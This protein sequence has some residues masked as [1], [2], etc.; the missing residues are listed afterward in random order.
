MFKKIVSLLM[1]AAMIVALAAAL[2]VSTAADEPEATP[3][4]W[5]GKANI[6]WYVDGK[7]EGV[8]E[9]HLKTAEDFAG[10]AWIVGAGNPNACYSGVYYDED[11]YVLG[12][13][14]T[15]IS[16][17]KPYADSSR[18]HKQ[19][20]DDG[21]QLIEG[22][23]FLYETVY[24]DTDVILNE[25]NAAD[26]AETAPANVWLPIGGCLNPSAKE[27]GFNGV[28]EGE[29]HT[30]SGAYF[31]T[32]DKELF[33][34]G[35]FGYAGTS[36]ASTFKNFKLKN[37]FFRSGQA[38]A[39]I[40]GRSN[41]PITIK[42]CQ[43][44][45][46]IVIN[47]SGQGAGLVAGVFNGNA[48]FENC[49]LKNVSVEATRYVGGFVGCVN[50][51][52]VTVK[53]CSITGTVTAK[54]I[55]VEKGDGN[56]AY[57]FGC[58]AGIIIGR[59]AGGS[60][61]VENFWSDV[62]V[63]QYGK[64][65]DQAAA[66]HNKARAGVIFAGSGGVAGGDDFAYPPYS[67]ESVYCVNKFNAVEVVGIDEIEGAKILD[68]FEFELI[69]PDDL[70]GGNAEYTLAGF[71]FDGVWEAVDSGYPEIRFAEFVQADIDARQG[72]D[73]GE[74]GDEPDYNPPS[75]VKPSGTTDGEKST[76]VTPENNTTGDNAGAEKKGCGSVIAGLPVIGMIALA[77]AAMI[78]RK[79]ED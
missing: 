78:R 42:N 72:E 65:E 36:G 11:Y 68:P 5:S 6:K 16:E 79:K 12:F 44:E 40:C 53:N 8:E 46:C 17:Q 2:P 28:F 13:Q 25:G 47:H 76:T 23:D 71:D 22:H 1:V 9:W 39:T 55:E 61:D 14:R 45:D 60:Y 75:P 30:I 31:S 50:G 51:V 73:P 37:S 66:A 43:V 24:L 56:I 49:Q 62:T 19:K 67:I 20:K 7:A 57:T 33:A 63:N 48:L 18:C 15:D 74:G 3:S 10:L 34:V 64:P 26:W 21:S 59:A 52:S 58:E 35:L 4:V 70:L 32:D 77:G 41:K 69:D 54:A 27:P 29:G 38:T